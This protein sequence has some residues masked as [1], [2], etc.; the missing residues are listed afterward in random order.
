MN[1]PD[2]LVD[3]ERPDQLNIKTT[4]LALRP[5]GYLIVAIVWLAIFVAVIGVTAIIP[6]S[7]ISGGN[8]LQ[9][10]RNFALNNVV[11]IVEILIILTI[12]GALLGW[13]FVM[14]GLLSATNWLLATTYFL[15]S[16]RPSYSHEKLSTTKWSMDAIGPVKAGQI[17]GP[18]DSLVPIKTNVPFIEK[19]RNVTEGTAISLIPLRDSKVTTFLMSLSLIAMVGVTGKIFKGMFFFGLSYML[20]IGWVF[21][22]VTNTAGVIIWLIIS[23]ALFIYGF[24]T[25]VKGIRIKLAIWD[26]ESR[27][28]VK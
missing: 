11:N 24:V 19:Y 12:C 4:S 13:G 14:L 5:F 1:L 27:K 17:I 2:N 7:L 8:H 3:I 6:A 16:L 9:D 23:L 20:T 10:S 18:D 22:P 25:I 28:A 15:R 26:K 21:W